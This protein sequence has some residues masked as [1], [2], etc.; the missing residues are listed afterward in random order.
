MPQVDGLQH[1]TNVLFQN[2][3]ETRTLHSNIINI[4]KYI[5]SIKYLCTPNHFRLSDILVVYNGLDHHFMVTLC[6]VNRTLTSADPT[7]WVC[8]VGTRAQL[9][10]ETFTHPTSICQGNI[11]EPFLK[12]GSTNGSWKTKSYKQLIIVVTETLKQLWNER[13]KSI[14]WNHIKLIQWFRQ[15]ILTL[16][17]D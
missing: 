12:T 15:T 2:N 8:W 1:E 10:K 9:Q 7:K 14:K 17:L 13:E 11:N 4:I 3:S 5:H 6:A 16:H